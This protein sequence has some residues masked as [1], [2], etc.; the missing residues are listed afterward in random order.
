MNFLHLLDS[1]ISHCRLA[2]NFLPIFDHIYSLQICPLDLYRRHPS[3]PHR[4]GHRAGQ[5]RRHL[6]EQVRFI[7]SLTHFLSYPLYI[8]AN[9]TFIHSANQFNN[10]C[11]SIYLSIYQSISVSSW[12]LTSWSWTWSSASAARAAACCWTAFPAP[13]PR[14]SSSP[15]TSRSTP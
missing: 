4:Q 13:P 5:G 1:T 14:R 7:F 11:N 8:Q 15:S 10:L 6:H 9:I 2:L 3:L 12:F